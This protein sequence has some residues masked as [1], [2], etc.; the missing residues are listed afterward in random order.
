MY[1]LPNQKFGYEARN[2]F[3]D[4]AE[5]ERQDFLLFSRIK[6][7]LDGSNKITNL[8]ADND[9]DTLPTEQLIAMILNYVRQQ[10]LE[11]IRS[12]TTVDVTED[13]VRWVITVPA[14][15]EP[16]AKQVMLRAAQTANL[17]GPTTENVMLAL[18]PGELM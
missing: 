8:L 18:E 14:I 17:C 15:W 11:Q 13:R 9:Q 10:V 7:A 3:L 12:S 4:A 1:F 6:M 2:Y 16:W 5:T